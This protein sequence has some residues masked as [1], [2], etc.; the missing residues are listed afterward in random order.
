MFFCF[1]STNNS[2]FALLLLPLL[3][4]RNHQPNQQTNPQ[5]REAVVLLLLFRSK[6]SS[7]PLYPT[8]FLPKPTK[9]QPPTQSL[10]LIGLP[11]L[12]WLVSCRVVSVSSLA[13]LCLRIC[14]FRAKPCKQERKKK[15]G[16]PPP[17]LLLVGSPAPFG[18][19]FIFHPL[20]LP[21]SSHPTHTRPSISSPSFVDCVEHSWL[22]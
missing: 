4:L 21:A 10:D 9:N 13:L 3:P 18:I 1:S 12:L 16:F 20:S 11:L 15:K 14:D 5:S 17:F 2:F 6:F 19:I 8:A 22:V 7:T